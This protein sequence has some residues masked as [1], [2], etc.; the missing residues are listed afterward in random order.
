MCP[1]TSCRAHVSSK[2]QTAP[3]PDERVE[4]LLAVHPS[5]RADA[6]LSASAMANDA[7]R[8][9]RAASA[10][11]VAAT[12]EPR[13]AIE[14]LGRLAGDA[15][16]GV[17]MAAASALAGLSWRGKLGALGTLL[18]DADLG[19]AAMAAQGLAHAKDGR[20]AALLLDVCDERRLRFDA[21]EALFVLDHDGANDVARRLF[22]AFL[23]PPF[24]K[25]VA[26]L[27]LARQ[28]DGKARAHVLERLS[29]P[30]AEERPMLLVHALAALGPSV[31]DVVERVAAD[32]RDYLRESALLALVRHDSSVWPRVQAALVRWVD[33]DPH[34]SAELLLGLFDI[35]ADRAGLLV[36]AHVQRPDELGRAARRLRLAGQLRSTFPD[37]VLR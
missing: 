8:F 12:G 22:G 28:G 1:R 10:R 25:G 35:D 20:G 3:T 21:L 32:E 27:I 15:D 7:D 14:L 37:E 2:D 23:V 11:A 34:V 31:V 36:E 17:R 13:E 18:D 30:R 16:V 33:D 4:A 24:D 26:A 29:S 5:E 6:F 19:V 9:V